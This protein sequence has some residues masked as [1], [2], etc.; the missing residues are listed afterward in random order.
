V[1]YNLTL[2][3]EVDESF[4]DPNRQTEL[5]NSIFE[6]IYQVHQLE[7]HTI[8]LIP[9][10]SMPHTANG[11]IRRSICQKRLI[12]KSLPVIARWEINAIT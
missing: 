12:D 11:T 4:I 3:C 7:L 1:E 9:L 6:L 5:F 10:K 8:V 2:L